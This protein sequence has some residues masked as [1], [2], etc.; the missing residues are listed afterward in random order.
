[1]N[2]SKFNTDIRQC[3]GFNFCW[4]SFNVFG[5][6]ITVDKFTD[7]EIILFR[8]INAFLFI[9]ANWQIGMPHLIILPNQAFVISTRSFGTHSLNNRQ[10]LILINMNY[11]T[12]PIPGF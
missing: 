11:G 1:M 8:L 7:W 6:T 12:T 2:W 9:S 10:P 5:A 3:C 4:V